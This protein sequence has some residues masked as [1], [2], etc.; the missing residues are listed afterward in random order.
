MRSGLVAMGARGLLRAE[1]DPDQLAVAL[2]AA[3][4]GGLLLG[5]LRRDATPLRQATDAVLDHIRAHRPRCRHVDGPGPPRRR[6]H[7]DR[8]ATRCA[9]AGGVGVRRGGDRMDS[10]DGVGRRGGGLI[11]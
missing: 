3:V 2:L 9:E 11:V 10:R 5:Q 7:S 8:G 1:A 6:S 4:Q